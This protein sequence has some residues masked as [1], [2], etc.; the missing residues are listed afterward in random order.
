M[1]QNSRSQ[2]N[3]KTK[4]S[5]QKNRSFPKSSSSPYL[6]DK[7]SIEKDLE[8]LNIKSKKLNKNDTLRHLLKAKELA[9]QG[10]LEHLDQQFEEGQYEKTLKA[11]IS[12][13]LAEECRQFTKKKVKQKIRLSQL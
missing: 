13:D 1:V 11:K 6:A 3:K 9:L 10:P 7:R 4:S 5:T 12:K 8:N 2:E